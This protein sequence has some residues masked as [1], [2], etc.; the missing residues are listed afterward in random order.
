M[1]AWRCRRGRQGDDTKREAKN[2]VLYGITIASFDVIIVGLAVDTP[3]VWLL[4]GVL[5][6]MLWIALFYV[7]NATSVGE[8]RRDG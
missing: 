4:V 7:A 3:P 5:L 1:P 2:A 6:S 8:R